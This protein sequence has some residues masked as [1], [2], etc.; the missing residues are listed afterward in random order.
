M[1][2]QNSI[3]PRYYIIAQNRGDELI[4]GIEGSS[5]QLVKNAREL[6]KNSDMLNGFSPKEAALIGVIVGCENSFVARPK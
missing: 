5:Y 3:K 6:L 4:V 2:E 1:K